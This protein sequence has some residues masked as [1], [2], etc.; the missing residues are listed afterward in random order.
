MDTLPEQDQQPVDEWPTS[1]MN[2][3][4]VSVEIPAPHTSFEIWARSPRLESEAADDHILRG[5]E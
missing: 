2:A 5:L 4:I 1:A 3:D